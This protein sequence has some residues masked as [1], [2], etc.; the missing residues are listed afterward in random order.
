M[1]FYV[2][3]PA[4]QY[5]QEQWDADFKLG[6]ANERARL[7]AILTSPE[8]VGRENAAQSLA[9][10]SDMEAEAVIGLLA[11][12]P[13]AGPAIHGER[14]RDAAGGLVVAGSS[15]EERTD[16]WS[17][18]VAQANDRFDREGVQGYKG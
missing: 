14:S 6:Q 11:T 9:F 4:P 7:T 1:G 18:A 12:L 5:S 8:A 13:K 3:D 15:S 16:G 17:G 10:N 2:D